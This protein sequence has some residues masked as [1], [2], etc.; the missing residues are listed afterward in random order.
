MSTSSDK[1][2]TT[3]GSTNDGDL[4]FNDTMITI[5]IKASKPAINEPV[6]NCE[7][8]SADTLFT[9]LIDSFTG[10]APD[11]NTVWISFA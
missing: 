5:A 10:N 6:S 8:N 7:P 3:I 1:L 2:V 11:S 9:P 4:Y